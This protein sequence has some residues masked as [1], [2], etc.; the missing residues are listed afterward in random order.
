MASKRS[1]IFNAIV[2]SLSTSTGIQTVEQEY[3]NWWDYMPHQFPCVTVI[4]RETSI[5]RLSYRSTSLDDMQA[6]INLTLRGYVH[7]FA[8][9]SSNLATARTNLVSDMEKALDSAVNSTGIRDVRFTSI[10]TDR[11]TMD[12]YSIIDLN[13]EVLY[14]YNHLSP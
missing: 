10:E 4:D 12:N 11:G 7:D 6:S 13:C 1:N 3:A 5:E 9:S 8:D 14:F 2:S